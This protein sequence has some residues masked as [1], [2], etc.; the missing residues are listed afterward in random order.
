MHVRRSHKTE[1][2]QKSLTWASPRTRR[3]SRWRKRAETCKTQLAGYCSR[4]MRNQNEMQRT[5]HS[6][7]EALL[8]EAEVHRIGSEVIKNR[9]RVGCDKKVGPHLG[10]D[11]KTA[12]LPQRAKRMQ[13]K[14]LPI[15]ATNCSNLRILSGKPAR[16]RWPRPWQTS[17][18]NAMP[19]SPNGCQKDQVVNQV[20]Q[21]ARGVKILGAPLNERLTRLLC[22]MRHVRDFRKGLQSPPPVKRLKSLSKEAANLYSSLESA[23]L[24][25]LGS[26][27]SNPHWT[28]D[29]PR[30]LVAR[31]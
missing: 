14:W 26:W 12:N 21:A 29:L 16:S 5:N 27:I 3:R 1:P 31:M 30:S 9:Y 23:P 15:W 4:R 25:S 28:S 7:G 13:Q 24:H 10:Q 8:M 18:K 17:S 2:L 11:V 22:L 20:G 6:L 19:V